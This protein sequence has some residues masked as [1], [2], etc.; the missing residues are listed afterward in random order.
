[1]FNL[2]S[3]NIHPSGANIINNALNPINICIIYFRILVNSNTGHDSPLGLKALEK[4]DFDFHE[5]GGGGLPIKKKSCL[6]SW[7]SYRASS[8]H[9]H[10]SETLHAVY[11][12]LWA[13]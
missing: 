12:T 5:M 6:Y 7:F 2:P 3:G 10:F 9:I 13:I 1:M 8:A 4:I 11:I